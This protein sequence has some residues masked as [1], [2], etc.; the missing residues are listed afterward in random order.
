M[1]GASVGLLR[2]TPGSGKVSWER[3]KRMLDFWTQSWRGRLLW[4]LLGVQAIRYVLGWLL[5]TLQHHI[6]SWAF[7]TA[8]INSSY[9]LLLLSPRRSAAK[10]DLMQGMRRSLQNTPKTL[11]AS[12]KR[13]WGAILKMRNPLWKRERGQFNAEQKGGIRMKSNKAR[14]VQVW[15]ECLS[16][17]WPSTILVFLS[18][19][20]RK[21][22]CRRMASLLG[23]SPI[24]PVP[25]ET[26]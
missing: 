20:H 24:G 23:P 6:K 26:L 2:G 22:L 15:S 11:T 8:V 1:Q 10:W 14:Q 7:I 17:P 21:Q 13:R 25:W 18:Q 5:I 3:G 16:A 9:P 12:V 4:S 19:K